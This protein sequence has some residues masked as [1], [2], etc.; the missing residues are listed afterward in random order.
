MTCVAAVQ[1]PCK[2][3]IVAQVVKSWV[4]QSDTEVHRLA[5]PQLLYHQV[6]KGFTDELHI[7]R[8]QYMP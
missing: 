4:A 1:P 2:A 6:V 8:E 3:L 5:V 7:L